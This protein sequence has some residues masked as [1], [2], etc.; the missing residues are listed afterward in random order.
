MLG[1]NPHRLTEALW[2]CLIRCAEKDGLQACAELRQWQRWDAKLHSTFSGAPCV[3]EGRTISNSS[4]LTSAGGFT[5]DEPSLC[6]AL[7]TPPTSAGPSTMLYISLSPTVMKLLL[8]RQYEFWGHA[9]TMLPWD[10]GA[11]AQWRIQDFCEGDA[12]GVWPPIF[13]EEM[14]PTFYGR[15][16]ARIGVARIFQ[17]VCAPRGGSRISGWGTMHPPWIRQCSSPHL[18]SGFFRISTCAIITER[19][20]FS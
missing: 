11:Q 12:A 15:L 5:T 18:S 9:A 3:C 17:T 6:N 8:T 14:T 16:L 19:V 1:G 10:L 13:S 20:V 2:W 4:G 7:P